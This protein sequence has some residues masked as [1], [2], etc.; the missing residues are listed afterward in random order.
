MILKILNWI[1][2]IPIAKMAKIGLII[3]KNNIL[4]DESNTK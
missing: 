1:G 4:N 3:S 2:S